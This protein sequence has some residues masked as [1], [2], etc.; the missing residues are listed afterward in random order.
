MKY[1]FITHNFH[2]K[3]P[4]RPEVISTHRETLLLKYCVIKWVQ[5]SDFSSLVQ[6]WLKETI[7][8]MR[9]RKLNILIHIIN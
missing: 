8:E 5:K 6:C 4:K 1:D 9:E 3:H 2:S 7:Q